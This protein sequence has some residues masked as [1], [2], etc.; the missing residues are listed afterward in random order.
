MVRRLSCHSLGLIVKAAGPLKRYGL[1]EPVSL[2]VSRYGRRVQPPDTE[3]RLS[4][5]GGCRGAIPVTRPDR[6]GLTTL[7]SQ[8]TP[9]QRSGTN[10]LPSTVTSIPAVP[11]TTSSM[12]LVFSVSISVNPVMVRKTQK[13]LSFIQVPISEP[14]PMAI[15]T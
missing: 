8:A 14:L 15:S 7:N 12:V 5:V 2:A 6:R 1:V 13:P 4:G 3:N 9:C 10:W 11:S